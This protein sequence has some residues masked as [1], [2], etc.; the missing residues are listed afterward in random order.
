MPRGRK[1]GRSSMDGSRG[2][3][4]KERDVCARGWLREV[5]TE[6]PSH[7]EL[8]TFSARLHCSTLLLYS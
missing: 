8:V 1:G 4:A 3:C 7:S 2:A 6:T 5:K